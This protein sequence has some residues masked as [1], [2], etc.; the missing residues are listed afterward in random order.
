M[1]NHIRVQWPDGS[2]LPILLNSDAT[3][4]DLKNMLRFAF[5]PNEILQLSINDFQ[6]SNEDDIPMYMYGL[7]DGDTIKAIVLTPPYRFNGGNRLQKA[8]DSILLEAAKVSDTHMNQLESTNDTPLSE[9]KPSTNDLNFVVHEQATIIPSKTD[10]IN[11]SPIPQ[12]FPDADRFEN[13]ETSSQIQNGTYLNQKPPLFNSI[14][15][16]GDYFCNPKP[17][18]DW[19]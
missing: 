5:G 2:I 9:P 15:E 17:D 13:A 14:E 8:I 10:E 7:K 19:R 3:T 18:S 11:S 12:I 1:I 16:A 4:T 6:I